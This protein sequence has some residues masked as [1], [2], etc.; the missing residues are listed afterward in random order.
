MTATIRDLQNELT[1]LQTERAAI[2]L[3]GLQTA[4]EAAKSA[5]AAY[6]PPSNSYVITDQEKALNIALSEASNAFDNAKYRARDLD[7]LAAPLL[8]MLSAPKA[9]AQ[10]RDDLLGLGSQRHAAQTAVDSAQATVDTLR[11][12]LADAHATY[13][14]HRESAA[15]AVLAG[16]KEGRAV[17]VAPPDRAEVLSIE[18]ATALAEQ[19]LADTQQAL[20]AVTAQ[21]SEAEA[22]L[23]AASKAAAGLQFELT[24]RDFV[25]AVCDYREAVPNFDPERAGIL[26]RVRTLEQARGVEAVTVPMANTTLAS[27]HDKRRPTPQTYASELMQGWKSPRGGRK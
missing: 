22:E 8:A 20:D 17:S 16:A 21:I 9:A 25:E 19:E 14:G 1:A 6:T 12:L 27:I 5:K 18:S 24:L 23:R 13:A 11:G 7:H 15:K 26:Q 2:N 3:D 10:T 4:F